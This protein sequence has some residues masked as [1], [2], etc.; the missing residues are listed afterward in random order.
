MGRNLKPWTRALITYPQR[1]LPVADWL[2]DL[3]AED[4]VEAN[5]EF[6]R[7]TAETYDLTETCVVSPHAQQMLDSDLMLILELL[8]KP[9]GELHA[10]DACGGSGNVATK[11]LKYGVTVTLCDI[12]PELIAIFI[13]RAKR[14]GSQVVVEQAEIN[15]FLK[16]HGPKYDLIV[17]SSA[18]HHLKDYASV[19]HDC[20][21]RLKPGGMVYTVFD[22]TPNAEL[23]WLT[24]GILAIDY[25][26]FKLMN[27]PSDVLAGLHRRWR[28]M[29]QSSPRPDRGHAW[30]R[31]LVSG[32]LPEEY[33]GFV[34]EY[35]ARTGIDDLQL[36]EQLRGMGYRVVWHERYAS[37]RH[38]LFRR[39]LSRMNAVTSFKLL[40]QT[41][42]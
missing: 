39:I 5:R 25:L 22:P 1:T 31:V 32:N 14:Y 3:D 21:D 42:P 33:V 4:V 36:A 15:D 16:K 13:Q 2:N 17:F 34:A 10:L 38:G 29:V 11:L 20:G 37:A 27:H 26:L 24:R 18:L 8:S 23:N 6:Y 28:R 40:L 41:P 35:F 9:V 12:S 19:L 30:D 7:Q